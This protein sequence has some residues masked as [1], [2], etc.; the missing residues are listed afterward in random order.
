VCI[1]VHARGDDP[2]FRA[3]AAGCEAAGYPVA[4]L[5]PSLWSPADFDPN[6]DVAVVHGL[7]GKAAE[8]HARYRAAETAVV[9]LDLPR[10]RTEPNAVGLFVNDLQWL[11]RRIVRTAVTG[12]VFADRREDVALVCG[13]LPGDAAH[14]M[15]ATEMAEWARRAI[16]R[17]RVDT[18]LP[19]VYRPHPRDTTPIPADQF[20]ADEVSG[21]E[22]LA[23]Q[24]VRA[25]LVVTYNS[26]AGWEAIAA[27]V[28][29]T[30]DDPKCAYA[31]FQGELNAIWRAE[32]LALAAS[33]QWTLAELEQEETIET[34]LG[35]IQQT[36][37]PDPE[38]EPL[39]AS[40]P[41][42]SSAPAASSASSA[43]SARK[44]KRDRRARAL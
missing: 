28:P 21:G 5:R 19:V 20:G 13:Q 39:R 18:G 15:T 8:I 42:A 35:Q 1:L 4:W 10:L 31:L 2:R 34:L 26:T 44:S 41:I 7:R 25:A 38:P 14:G 40:P 32:A 9:I 29:V 11:P 23:S 22:S 30:C 12:P 43:P 33:S 6:V 3:F 16:T 27:G 17:T 37:E 24:F 36:I